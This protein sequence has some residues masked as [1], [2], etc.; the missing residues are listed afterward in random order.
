MKRLLS[1]G[2]LGALLLAGCGSGQTEETNGSLESMFD[3]D[4]GTAGSGDTVTAGE[5]PYSEGPSEIP[6]DL[7]PHE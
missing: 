2:L 5:V 7:I 4:S 1:L 6:D 3:S